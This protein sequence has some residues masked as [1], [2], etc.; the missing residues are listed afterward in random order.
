MNNKLYCKYLKTKNPNDQK[1]YKSYKSTL[2]SILCKAERT[3]YDQ[4]F[5]ATKNNLRKTWEVIKT[6]IHKQKNNNKQHY[7]MEV[8]GKE[9][10]DLDTIT[11]HFNEYFINVGPNQATSIP[12]SNIDPISYITQTNRYSMFTK[13]TN[14]TKIGNIIRALKNSPPGPD[15][16]PYQY[17]KK[18]QLTFIQ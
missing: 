14:E 17:S 12:Y 6:V 1:Q 7:N 15:A 9:T 13:L 16:F 18:T 3:H 5:A 8:N 11:K 4:L 10:S 2:R